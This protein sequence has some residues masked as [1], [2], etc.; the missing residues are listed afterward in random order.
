MKRIFKDYWRFLEEPIYLSLF[1]LVATTII[2]Y[3]IINYAFNPYFLWII[4]FKPYEGTWY[5]FFINQNII[6]PSEF[7]IKTLLFTITL[8]AIALIS[9][10][11]SQ[12]LTQTKLK[13]FEEETKSKFQHKK[14][15]KINKNIKHIYN[16]YL[17]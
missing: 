10:T 11:I 13:N 1:T 3:Q 15:N 17:I 5:S 8:S 2:V 12:E 4:T 6:S 14:I 7:A 9:I 16:K